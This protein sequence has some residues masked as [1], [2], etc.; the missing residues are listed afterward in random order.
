M[1]YEIILNLKTNLYE[2]VL[3][4]LTNVIICVLIKMTSIY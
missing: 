2:D 1:F 3:S 4:D